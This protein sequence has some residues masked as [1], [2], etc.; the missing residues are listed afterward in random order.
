MRTRFAIATG[1]GVALLFSVPALAQTSSTT[2]QTTTTQTAA[3]AK[4]REGQTGTSN[5]NAAQQLKNVEKEEAAAYKPSST[6][7]PKPVKKAK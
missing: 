5:S 3:D 4:K 2:K 6:A 1:I 7:S